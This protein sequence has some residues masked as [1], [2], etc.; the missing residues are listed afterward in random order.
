MWETSARADA[1]VSSWLGATPTTPRILSLLPDDPSSALAVLTLAHVALVAPVNPGLSTV[2]LE[3]VA[4]RLEPGAVLVRADHPEDRERLQGLRAPIVTVEPRAGTHCADFDLVPPR[5]RPPGRASDRPGL[6]LS[7]SGSTGEPKLVP[8]TYDQM[9][10]SAAHIASWLRLGP[11]DRALHMLPLFHVGAFVDLVLAALS[12]GGS[13]RFAHPISTER[14]IATIGEGRAT[15]VQ[16]VPTMLHHLLE[17]HDGQLVEPASRLRF[18][19]TVSADLAPALQERA[20]ELF[21]EVPIIQMYGMTETAGQITSNPIAPGSV[22]PGTVGPPAGPEVMVM[23]AHANPRAVGEIGEVCVSGP[24]VMA[25]YL[26]H[27]NADVFFG[28]WFRTGDLGYLDDAGFLTL[29]G[30]RKDMINR[31]GEKIAPV[32]IER[33]LLS[34]PDVL[35]AAAFGV[36]HPTLGEEAM[37]AAVAAPGRRLEADRL[38]EYTAGLLADFKRPR[39]IVLLEALPRLG[40]GK[41][42]RK[43]LRALVGTSGAGHEKS[44]EPRTEIG[45]VLSRIWVETLG[46]VPPGPDSDFFDEGGDSLAA[47]TF[48]VRVEASLGVTLPANLLFESPT[49]SLLEHTVAGLPRRKSTSE[50]LAQ[51]VRRATAA[52]KGVRAGPDDLLVGWRTFGTMTP[53]FFVV[54]GQGGAETLLSALHPERPVY[55]MRPLS[56]LRSRFG[57][58]LQNERNKRRIAELY[59]DGI[60]A[61]QPEGPVLLGGFCQGAEVARL[62]AD[63]LR[64]DGRDV[65][66]LAVVDRVFTDPVPE[67]A[68]VV[69]TTGSEHSGDEQF[70]SS[71]RHLDL[72]Y[73]AGCSVLHLP[74]RHAQA[75]HGASAT[76]IA[77][78]LEEEFARALSGATDRRTVRL[79]DDVARRRRAHSARIR[80][81]AP[82]FSG[83][84]E[85]L[86]VRATVTNTSPV[87]W[88]GSDEGEFGLYARWLNLDAYVRTPRAAEVA[89]GQV[90]EP[91][92]TV[93]IDLTVPFPD[94]RLPMILMVDVVDDGLNWFH[95][96]GSRPA[97]RLVWPAPLRRTGSA[98]SHR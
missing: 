86:S 14:L 95:A 63:A 72:L 73:P 39:R 98:S 4:A 20:K 32:E 82:R 80:L 67:R 60:H 71:E 49:F 43:R 61:V 24:T 52:W 21:R 31:G 2:E 90:V 87:P 10:Q 23:D 77:K 94:K 50:P 12:V 58:R 68:A 85:C 69:W 57:R 97:Y 29:T 64:A 59:R 35:E 27:D 34:H 55:A 81:R 40:S 8:L 33:V 11:D 13:V 1:V 76:R 30:R 89:L 15:W 54:R 26:D 51:A 84:G 42:D 9:L 17:Q 83:P 16:L 46:S 75:L 36:S 18:V 45:R 88:N 96:V 91:G 44:H 65:A 25:G 48:V 93:E 7:T 19:R 53:F 56:G 3:E 37:A 6:V 22:R 41:I 5:R 28:P 62:V 47:T 66:L 70:L 74:V 79:A 78:F 92:Q 38:L